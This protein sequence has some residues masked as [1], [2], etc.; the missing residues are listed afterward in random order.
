MNL[1]GKKSIFIFI[2]LL[3][4][5][6]INFFISPSYGYALTIEDTG[7]KNTRYKGQR[8]DDDTEQRVKDAI[9]EAMQDIE[10]CSFLNEFQMPFYVIRCGAHTIALVVNAG[11]GKFKTI[12]EKVREFVIE[13]RKSPKKEQEL[14]SLAKKLNVKYR[15]LIRDVKTRWNST[16]SML[17]AFLSNKTTIIS[18]ITINNNFTNLDLNENE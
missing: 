11:L 6:S 14:S 12:I 18:T 7:Y 15:K 10:N 8:V 2:G 13:I 4:G 16:Y 3:L 17:E 9:C 1:P 5:I